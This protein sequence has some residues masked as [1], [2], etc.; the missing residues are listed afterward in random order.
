MDKVVNLYIYKLQIFNK[1]RENQ[2]F[3]KDNFQKELNGA[4]SLN[5]LLNNLMADL[6]YLHVLEEEYETQYSKK[7]NNNL[8]TSETNP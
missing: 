7:K 4:N 2:S 3:L 5:D 1:N 8:S 6:K